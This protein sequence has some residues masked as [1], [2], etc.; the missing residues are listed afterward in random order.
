MRRFRTTVWT[1]AGALLILTLAGCG[2]NEVEQECEP[3]QAS[4]T[5]RARE[6]HIASEMGGRVMEI[7]AEASADVEAGE[8]VVTLDA[9][10][11][12]LELSQAE[13]EVNLA[14][15]ELEQ[16][17][18]GPR[19]EEVEAA[20]AAVALA[21]A[22]LDGAYAAWQNA[23]EAVEDPQDIDAQII[24]ARTQVELAVQGVERAEAQLARERLLC[25]QHPSGS[26]D[27][28]AAEH[29]V[30]AAEEAL[31]AAQAEEEAARRLLGQLWHI[32]R[33]PLGLIAQEHAAEGQY[34]MAQAAVDEAQAR[35]DDLLARPTQEEVAVAEAALRQ[36]QAKAEL[37]RLQVERAKLRSPIDGVVM[38]QMVNVGEVAGPAAPILVVADLRHVRL[39]VYV[40]ERC[41]GR[42]YLG[43]QVEIRVDTFPDQVFDGRV[44]RIGDEPEYTPRNVATQEDRLNTFYV[45]EIV[46]DNAEGKLKPGMPADAVFP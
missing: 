11:L 31:A 32:R 15:A 46:V 19:P 20:Q 14:Q 7:S 37:L 21:E 36:A 27:R 42:V 4:G 35:L 12:L 29:K 10:P 2:G 8:V 40:S 43:E 30:H 5:L 26:T 6:V 22:K 17:K 16:V 9:T 3:I 34:R 24:E 33:E 18:A 25:Q 28:E 13:A 39:H 38:E 1:L 23:K 44:V 41:I 45:V